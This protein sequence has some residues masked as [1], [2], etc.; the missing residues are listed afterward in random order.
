[1]AELRWL[2][3]WSDC[4][5]KLGVCMS[6]AGGDTHRCI[7]VQHGKFRLSASGC[8]LR[9]AHDW[10]MLCMSSALGGQPYAPSVPSASMWNRTFSP[11]VK[12]SCG[13]LQYR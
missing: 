12:V 5:T 10:T 4:P 3:T 11:W 13:M 8:Q 1:M 6:T 7:K 2:S 9:G